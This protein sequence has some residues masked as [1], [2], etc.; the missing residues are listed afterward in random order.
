M[1]EKGLT[2]CNHTKL[3]LTQSMPQ[4]ILSVCTIKIQDKQCLRIFQHSWS[5]KEL[6]CTLIT[7][8]TWLA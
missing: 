2:S 8:R 3:S 5:S 1:F 6:K 7:M 4:D